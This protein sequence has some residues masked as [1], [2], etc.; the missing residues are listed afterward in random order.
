MKNGESK[1][2][3]VGTGHGTCTC[4]GAAFEYV[5]NVDAELRRNGVREKTNL[6]YLTNEYQLG[7]FGVDGI[8]LDTGGFI[9]PSKV[10][11]ESLF[12]EK[13]IKWYLG[14]HVEKVEKNL[15]S[16]TNLEGKKDQIDFD[17]AMLLPPFKGHL[18]RSFN[19]KGEEITD[20]LFNPNNFM[21][22]DADYTPKE[23]G[24]WRAEDWPRHYQ[25]P[26]YQNLFAVGIAFAPP[27][28][29]SKPRKNPEGISITPSPPR[30]GMPSAMMGRIVAKNIAQK[31]TT[32]ILGTQT[33]SMSELGAA[34]V[35]SIGTGFS[36][37][38]AVSITMFPIV[39]DFQKY[40]ET[41]RNL[42]YTFS[43]IG[44]A[45]HWIKKLLHYLFIYKAKAKA[46][47]W[48][49]PE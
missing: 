14:S 9:T 16:F 20:K 4:E 37:G 18:L 33:A 1:T 42:K 34:C 27:H 5:F 32:G 28:P 46:F 19:Q 13:G 35:A 15:V 25:S 26:L 10:M 22:V 3:V 2:I 38:A 49:I 47:W 43:E 44:R 45:G 11:A 31:I 29:I 21:K 7:D 39:P 30:T 23:Y 36:T 41:G 8:Q 12:M 24:E 40:P 48:I 17:F 6:I